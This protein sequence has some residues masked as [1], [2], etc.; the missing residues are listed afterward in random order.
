MGSLK[1]LLLLLLLNFMVYQHT[2]E[3]LLYLYSYVWGE[4]LTSTCEVAWIIKIIN[5]INIYL[6]SY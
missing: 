4:G 6:A 5:Y 1:E 2:G 3:W